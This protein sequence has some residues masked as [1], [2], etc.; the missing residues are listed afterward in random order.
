MH[1]VPKFDLGPFQA[2]LTNNFPASHPRVVG[3]RHGNFEM[4]RGCPSQ[5]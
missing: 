1:L 5:R 3:N 2:F 4:I